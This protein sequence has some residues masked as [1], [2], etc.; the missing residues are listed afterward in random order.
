MVR[1]K[2]PS[3]DATMDMEFDRREF[4]DEF[5]H[6]GQTVAVRIRRGRAEAVSVPT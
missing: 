3:S 1:F 2:H 5:C 4:P 6:V